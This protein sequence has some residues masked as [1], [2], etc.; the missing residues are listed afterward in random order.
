[1]NVIKIVVDEVPKTCNLCHFEGYLDYFGCHFCYAAR[2]SIS[3]ENNPTLPRPSW[4]PLVVENER[5]KEALEEI[6]DVPNIANDV[7]WVQMMQDIAQQA[8][9]EVTHE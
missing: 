3:R 7:D 2:K 5:L 9:N 4:C 1:M 8:L 6:V